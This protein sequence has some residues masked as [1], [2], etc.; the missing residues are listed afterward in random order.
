[1]LQ[2]CLLLLVWIIPAQSQF[3]SQSLSL[4]PQYFLNSSTVY[5]SLYIHVCRCHAEDA[6]R[7][8]LFKVTAGGQGSQDADSGVWDLQEVLHF[9]PIHMVLNSVQTL[10]TLFIPGINIRLADLITR[11]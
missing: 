2:T 1:M 4:S 3:Q 5:V 11:G 6:V 8:L 10:L 7:E 9:L